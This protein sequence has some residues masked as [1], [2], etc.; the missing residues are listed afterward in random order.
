VEELTKH[1]LISGRVQGVG[2]RRFAEKRARDLKLRGWVRNLDDGR[3]EAMACGPQSHLEQFEIQ[4][5]SG[6]MLGHVETLV[7]R[8]IGETS[9]LEGFEVRKDSAQPWSEK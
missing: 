6:P 8:L 2:Y 4:L 7:I 9:P 5:K 3:V 1:Y